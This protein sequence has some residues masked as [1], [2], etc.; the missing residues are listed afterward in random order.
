MLTVGA[1]G[2]LGR[3]HLASLRVSGILHIITHSH[4]PRFNVYTRSRSSTNL[5]YP[6]L[7]CKVREL[8]LQYPGTSLLDI[9]QSS[10]G[11]SSYSCSPKGFLQTGNS[12]LPVLV[13]SSNTV[14]L[15]C[16][17]IHSECGLI[18]ERRD[19]PV[20][21]SLRSIREYASSTRSRSGSN[22]RL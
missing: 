13:C 7:Y 1:V 16:T 18:V 3:S 6:A 10:K 12:V 20:K 22:S 2:T 8:R 15:K 14:V 5:Q 11:G 21:Q 9:G 19:F 4:T 17:G